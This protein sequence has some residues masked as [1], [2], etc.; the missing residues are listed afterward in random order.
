MIF[1]FRWQNVQKKGANN[2]SALLY[3][4]S[5]L[6][7][8]EDFKVPLGGMTLTGSEGERKER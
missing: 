8:T 1:S 6:L 4:F 2:K 3:S 7:D 5:P